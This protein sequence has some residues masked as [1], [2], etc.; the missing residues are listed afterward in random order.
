M[1]VIGLARQPALWPLA[2]LP[3]AVPLGHPQALTFVAKFMNEAV[4]NGTLRNA[5][6]NNGGLLTMRV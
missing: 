3:V 4:T 6:V 5:Y 1:A 2:V